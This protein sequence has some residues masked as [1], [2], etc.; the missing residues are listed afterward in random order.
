MSTSTSV[1]QAATTQDLP[2]KGPVWVSKF[3]TPSPSRD[4][5][6]RELLLGL[7]DE[8]NSHNIHYDRP[9]CEQLSCEWTGYRDG[10]EAGTPEPLLPENEKCQKLV[11]GTKSSMAVHSYST[12]LPATEDVLEA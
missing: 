10:V 3:T 1:Q 11:E 8:A 2:V 5:N 12:P 4:D 7:N 9:S 6:S